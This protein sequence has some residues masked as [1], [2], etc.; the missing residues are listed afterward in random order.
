MYDLLCINV[1]NCT[2][3]KRKGVSLPPSKSNMIYP[4]TYDNLILSLPNVDKWG[5]IVFA[6]KN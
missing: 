1:C 2:F 5:N 3:D 6:R 4:S